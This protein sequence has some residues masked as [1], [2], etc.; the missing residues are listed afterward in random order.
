MVV[1]MV[2]MRMIVGMIMIVASM[3]VV[4]AGVIFVV[5][6]NH[7]P[8]LLAAY[9]F[10]GDLRLGDQKINDLLLKHGPTQFD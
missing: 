3:I 2:I 1:V 7:G 8:Q 10:F 4:V 5:V 6:L 9:R